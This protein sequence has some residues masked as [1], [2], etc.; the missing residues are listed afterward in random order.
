VVAAYVL[1][2]ALP[3]YTWLYVFA[4]KYMRV[5]EEEQHVEEVG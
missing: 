1:V 5:Y 4:G 3:I 2:E